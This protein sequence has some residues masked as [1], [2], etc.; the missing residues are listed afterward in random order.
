MIKP[1]RPVDSS[2]DASLLPMLLSYFAIGFANG[3]SL[4][5][6]F[7]NGNLVRRPS[8]AVTLARGPLPMAILCR[9]PLSLPVSFANGELWPGDSAN[10]DVCP[11]SLGI[12]VW[13]TAGTARATLPAT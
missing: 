10:G 11:V 8:L 12:F 13:A 1:S 7:A 4:P 9:C 2:E 3:D 6:S 5:G